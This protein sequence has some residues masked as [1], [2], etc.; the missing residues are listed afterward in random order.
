[1]LPLGVDFFL[2]PWFLCCS[3]LSKTMPPE[4]AFAV[5]DRVRDSFGGQC[6]IT[7][8]D[9]A[10]EHG[11]GV[12]EAR[13][14]DGKT[15]KYALIAHGFSHFD[16][17]LEAAKKQKLA[18]LERSATV[19]IGED[20]I[21]IYPSDQGAMGGGFT[22]SPM[23]QLPHHATV[24]TILHELSLALADCKLVPPPTDL[25]ALLKPLLTATGEKTWN[26][27]ARSYACINVREEKELEAIVFDPWRP[28][29]GAFLGMGKEARAKTADPAALATAFRAAAAV[30]IEEQNIHNPPLLG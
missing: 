8:I 11:M 17:K 1:M 27:I 22:G 14:D 16:A 25:K 24:A 30:A 6:T 20:R 18:T 29:K 19:L 3:L 5:G 4:P 9:P 23:R 13:R 2:V 21:I 7:R 26:A 28:E 15:I 12:I 10:A